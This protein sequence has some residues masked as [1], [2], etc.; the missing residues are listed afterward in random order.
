MPA[1]SFKCNG[2]RPLISILPKTKLENEAPLATRSIADPRLKPCHETASRS[3]AA[4]SRWKTMRACGT[5]LRLSSRAL[6]AA[7]RDPWRSIH[8]RPAPRSAQG[9]H[10]ALRV[11][12]QHRRS[13][14][15][16]VFIFFRD[17]PLVVNLARERHPREPVH[18]PSSVR[19]KA[20]DCAHRVKW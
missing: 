8:S 3:A 17:S 6:A 10:T 18:M 7:S 12:Q 19:S 5:D 1:K 13:T 16:F 4:P 2:G 11:L 9:P 20:S 15:D 14:C